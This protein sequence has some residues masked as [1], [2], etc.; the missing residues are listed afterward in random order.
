LGT[1]QNLQEELASFTIST[2][3]AILSI[4]SEDLP[5]YIEKTNAYLSAGLN[6]VT[7]LLIAYTPQSLLDSQFPAH[8]RN[9]Q[10]SLVERGQ[11]L[12]QPQTPPT[13]Q[14]EVPKAQ[15]PEPQ[16][17]QPKAEE[18]KAAE[19]PKAQEPEP[20]TEQPKA[21]EPKAAEQPKAEA[22]QEE[23]STEEPKAQEPEPEVH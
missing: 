5:A 3:K 21:E 7:Q 8:L 10:Q 15:E 23:P 17:E 4:N 20:Q 11:K 16:T 2:K 18:L 6:T 9:W 12:I 1:S 22:Q 14:T 13:P 19:Q